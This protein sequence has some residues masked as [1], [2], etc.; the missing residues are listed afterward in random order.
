[1]KNNQWTDQKLKRRLRRPERPRKSPQAK[2]LSPSRPR[3]AL[4]LGR[5][6]R[7]NSRDEPPAGLE[8]LRLPPLRSTFVHFRLST[9]LCIADYIDQFSLHVTRNLLSLQTL[10]F[11]Y[12]HAYSMSEF[13]VFKKSLNFEYIIASRF[14]Q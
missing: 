5:V 11:N 1:M 3:A 12:H 14:A 13:S 4:L 7:T 6:P 2:N 10:C 8:R 9:F